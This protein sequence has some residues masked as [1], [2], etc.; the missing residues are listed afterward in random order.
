MKL[1]KLYQLSLKIFITYLVCGF[2]K[3]LGV[4]YYNPK[5]LS[6]AIKAQST[7]LMYYVPGPEI[8]VGF[9]IVS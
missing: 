6:L 2:V 7:V 5:L 8:I 9:G 3:D 1:Y 4:V